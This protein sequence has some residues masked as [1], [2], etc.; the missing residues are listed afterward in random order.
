[1]NDGDGLSPALR[2]WWGV[3]FSPRGAL[4]RPAAVEGLGAACK[5]L[6]VRRRSSTGPCCRVGPVRLAGGKKLCG[7]CDGRRGPEG[8]LRGS[9]D[10]CCIVGETAAWG[11][12]SGPRV[13][14]GVS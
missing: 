12:P 9:A 11:L 10:Y 1:M 7:P 5:H 13:E 4:G 14:K 3:L 2:S 6:Q 8:L